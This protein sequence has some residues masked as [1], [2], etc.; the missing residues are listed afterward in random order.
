LGE[1]SLPLLQAIFGWAHAADPQQP[2]TVGIWFDNAA[3]NAFTL[4]ASDFISF[5]EYSAEPDALRARIVELKAL[6]RPVVCTEYMARSRG[7][8]FSRYLPVFKQEGVGAYNWGLVSGKTQTIYPWGS[9]GGEPEPELWFHDI[10][11]PD[12]T[13]YA[14]DEV[15]LISSLAA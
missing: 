2:L 10:F 12:G 3:L 11:R 7:S 8:L 14:A 6:G 9:P 13:P 4:A 15:A 5:H 1:A